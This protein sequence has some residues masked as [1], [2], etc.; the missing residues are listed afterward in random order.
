MRY[1]I[2]YKAKWEKPWRVYDALK[3]VILSGFDSKKEA[4]VY[5]KQLG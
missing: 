4:K 1:V 2:V 3:H 5:K